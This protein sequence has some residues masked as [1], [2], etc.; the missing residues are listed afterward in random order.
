MMIVSQEALIK[1]LQRM[2]MQFNH[3]DNYVQKA[4]ICILLASNF[5]RQAEDALF[6]P[7]YL[8]DIKKPTA[9]QEEVYKAI[10][11]SVKQLS[12]ELEELSKN[13]TRYVQDR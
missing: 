9:E 4:N 6:S 7:G 3:C 8:P 12:Q 5:M 10:Y 11:K 1:E 13:S 2:Q